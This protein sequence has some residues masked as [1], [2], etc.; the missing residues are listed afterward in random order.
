MAGFGAAS[1]LQEEGIKPIMYDKSSYYG[2]HTMS[3][4]YE[5]GFVFDIGPHISFTKDERMPNIHYITY[6]GRYGDG[7]YMWTDESFKSGEAAAEAVLSRTAAAR[8]R[9]RMHVS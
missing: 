7:G 4:R 2:G 1:R 3:F 8:P 9:Q 6:C 5:T